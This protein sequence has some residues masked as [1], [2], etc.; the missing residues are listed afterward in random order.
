MSKEVVEAIHMLREDLIP[1]YKEL[2]EIRIT[3]E[4][5]H[6]ATN[7]DSETWKT[8]PATDKQKAFMTSHSI[9][10]KEP[11]SKGEASEKIDRYIEA[12]KK[13]R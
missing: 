12:Q 4:T 5:Y 6:P 3:L 13:G 2:R 9:P 7:E 11:I 1:I 8:D 10:F